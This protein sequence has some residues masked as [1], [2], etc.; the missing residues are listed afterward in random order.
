MAGFT[1]DE[2]VSKFRTEMDDVVQPYLWTDDEIIDFLDEAQTEFAMHTEIFK[3][4]SAT[5]AVTADYPYVTLPEGLIRVRRATLETNRSTP[6]TIRNF[7]EMDLL[8]SSDDYGRVISNWETEEGIP[9]FLVLDDTSGEGRLAPIPVGTEVPITLITQSN[10]AIVSST[11]HG[12]AT[13]DTV[14]IRDVVGMTEVNDL[15]FTVT[16]SSENLFTLDGINSSAY[17]AYV[18]SGVFIKQNIDTIELSYSRL[19]LKPLTA[20]SQTTELTDRRH[21]RSL[22]VFAKARAYNKHD[23]D[24][25]DPKM[26][27]GL[28][29]QFMAELEKFRIENTK[30]TRKPGVVRYGGY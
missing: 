8:M 22:L 5:V 25:Y 27:Q 2:L 12:L 4:R 21:Q 11:G 17:T 30:L 28:L 9:A 24:I 23:S 3:E 13:G 1:L 26:S 10:P 29:Q 19:P 16:V 20:T 15:E 7:N 6:L 14:I 18:S